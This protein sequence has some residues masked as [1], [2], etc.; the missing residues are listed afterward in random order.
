MATDTK[1]KSKPEAFVEMVIGRISGDNPDAAFRAA[2]SKADNPAF[3][4]QCWEYLIKWQLCD[5][6]RSR[7]RKAF[8]LIGAALAK[9]AKARIDGNLGIG[10]AIARCYAD[11]GKY[12]GHE[13]DGAKTKL[14][15][16]LACDTTEEA[17]D[18]L[19]PLLDFIKSREVPLN[20]AGLLKELLY[21]DEWFNDRIKPRWAKDFY[22]KKEEA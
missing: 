18:I 8:V 5:I 21:S 20:Y 22:Y 15:R 9:K 14:R 13:K 12:N 2:F 11:E 7:E 17:C 4:Y 16:L 1:A 3:E 19:R 10:Q 6:E